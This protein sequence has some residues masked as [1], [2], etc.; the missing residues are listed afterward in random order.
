MNAATATVVTTG[1]T[2]LWEAL[3]PPLLAAGIAAAIAMLL[4]LLKSRTDDR[5]RVR[6]LYAEAYE[7]YASYKEMPYAIRRRRVDDPAAERIRL[8]E[9][10]RE[11]QAR[12]DHF[13]TWTALENPG[14]GAAYADLLRELR[15]VAGASMHDAWTE[16]GTSTDSAMNMPPGRVD[17]SPLAPHEAAYFAAVRHALLPAWC[18]ALHRWQR[19]AAPPSGP[20]TAVRDVDE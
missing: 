14:V 20:S 12:L 10:I 3:P 8:S 13:K 15:R 5:A 4:H 7:W 11:I 9:A 1:S 17:L 18:R 2:G 19:R 6:V 16:P